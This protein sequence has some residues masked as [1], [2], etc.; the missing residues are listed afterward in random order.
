MNEETINHILGINTLSTLTFGS[1]LY[2]PLFGREW[3]GKW[4]VTEGEDIQQSS[5]DRNDRFLQFNNFFLE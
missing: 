1:W 5:P 3:T 2:R 4:V